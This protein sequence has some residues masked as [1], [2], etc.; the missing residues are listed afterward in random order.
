M[1]KSYILI[2]LFVIFIVIITVVGSIIVTGNVK[3]D[4]KKDILVVQNNKEVF[5]L[6][7]CFHS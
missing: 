4:E 7:P 2:I 1:K 5:L 3:I 6:H